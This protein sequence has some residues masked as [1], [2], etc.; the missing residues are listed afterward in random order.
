GASVAY[1]GALVFRSWDLAVCAQF[2]WGLHWVWHLLTALTASLLVYGL[3]ISAQ[4][5]ER[6]AKFGRR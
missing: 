4:P 5:E 3:A 1:L 2:P 6:D